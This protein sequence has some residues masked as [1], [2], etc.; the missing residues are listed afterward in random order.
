MTATYKPGNKVRITIDAT[1]IEEVPLY[2]EDGGSILDLAY[3]G[4]DGETNNCTLPLGSPA[5]TVTRADLDGEPIDVFGFSSR[6]RNCL[7]RQGIR[8]VGALV[9]CDENDLL[10]IR[11]FG[12]VA[13][14]EVNAKLAEHG[15][16]L[17]NVFAP[18]KQTGETA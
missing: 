7:T 15:L 17:R 16:K 12:H 9:A 18:R 13:L 11:S 5:V 8:T 1:V 4:L 2:G 6:V 14:R 3:E 10:N